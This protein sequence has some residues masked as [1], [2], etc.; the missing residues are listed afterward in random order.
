MMD[1]RFKNSTSHNDIAK[2][3]NNSMSNYRQVLYIN[4][5][6]KA[7]ACQS[8]HLG[9]RSDSRDRFAGSV[10]RCRLLFRVNV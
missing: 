10:G 2:P 6:N 1:Y 9:V 3:N 5:F 4:S 8:S 7:A